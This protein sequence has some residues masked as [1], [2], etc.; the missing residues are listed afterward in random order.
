MS[1]TGAIENTDALTHSQLIS[2]TSLAAPTLM[3][4][5]MQEPAFLRVA[6]RATANNVRVSFDPVSVEE[7]RQTRELNK[8]VRLGFV[9]PSASTR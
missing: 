2:D 7:E 6:V 4:P 3:R 1:T 8:S 5:V 9:P